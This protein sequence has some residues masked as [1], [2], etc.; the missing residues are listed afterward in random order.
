MC[1]FYESVASSLCTPPIT[2]LADGLAASALFTRSR[3]NVREYQRINFYI[4][5]VNIID[6]SWLWNLKVFLQLQNDFYLCNS[7]LKAHLLISASKF[8][9]RHIHLSFDLSHII[10]GF[11]ILSQHPAVCHTASFLFLFPFFSWG[12]CRLLQIGHKN[13]K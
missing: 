3:I 5:F 7:Y 9:C 8:S 4:F 13:K 11:L 1:T 6:V 2:L 10:I 12:S